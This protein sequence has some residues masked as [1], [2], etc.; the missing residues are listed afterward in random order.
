LKP[1][2]KNIWIPQAIAMGFST[3]LRNE[4]IFSVSHYP[5]HVPCVF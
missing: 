1:H 3:A 5:H 2:T 4:R